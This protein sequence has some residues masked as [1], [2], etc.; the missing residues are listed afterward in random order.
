MVTKSGV[1]LEILDAELFSRLSGIDL[2]VV[3]DQKDKKL[4][5]QHSSQLWSVLLPQ[6]CHI[7]VVPELDRKNSWCLVSCSALYAAEDA[8]RNHWCCAFFREAITSELWFDLTALQQSEHTQ[9][10]R[11]LKKAR[12]SVTEDYA[13]CEEAIV[14]SAKHDLETRIDQ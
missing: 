1:W 5:I 13:G 10:M 12:L 9:I 6:D 3:V 8:A 7:P 14:E 11:T 4:E 2:W